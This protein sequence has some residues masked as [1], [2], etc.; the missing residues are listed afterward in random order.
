MRHGVIG[1]VRSFAGGV[2]N[3]LEVDIAGD[4]TVLARNRETRVAGMSDSFLHVGGGSTRRED[5][6]VSQG[7]HRRTR[8]FF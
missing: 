8:G 2:Q 3:I 7:H 6:E 1:W 5:D 4:G